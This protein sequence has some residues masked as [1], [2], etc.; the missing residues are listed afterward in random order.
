MKPWL[1]C[2]VLVV[3]QVSTPLMARTKDLAAATAEIMPRLQAME[4]AANA[5]NADRHVSY[6]A[7]DPQL[8]FVMNDQA[9]VGYDALLKQQRTW[10]KDGHTDVKYVIDGKPDFRM[11]APGLVM[12]T[13]FLS[14]HR[15]GP[16]GKTQHSRF[17]ISALWQQ[18]PE[19]WKII[20]AHE[21]KVDK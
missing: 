15:T 20:Y 12:V 14:S 5:H 11:P 18:R 8:L 7:H 21:S 9:I 4:A 1:I 13:Y 6:Y 3:M 16:D 10:W 19:G 2:A 17:G